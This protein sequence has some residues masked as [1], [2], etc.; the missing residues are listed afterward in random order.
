MKTPATVGLLRPVVLLPESFMSLRSAWQH[1][2]ACH[3]LLHVR[4]RDW[5]VTVIEEL[6]R[7]CSGFIRAYGGFWL[8]HALR[9]NKLSMQRLC[10]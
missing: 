5:M 4:R 7:P 2:I 9:A 6:W 1:G 3:E 10:D 8:S